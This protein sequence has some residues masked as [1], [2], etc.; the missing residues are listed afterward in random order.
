[1]ATAQITQ[2][3]VYRQEM[4]ATPPPNPEAL[5]LLANVSFPGKLTGVTF[6]FLRSEDR[7]FC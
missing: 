6:S 3:M 1:M 5:A 4:P 7:K 2:R